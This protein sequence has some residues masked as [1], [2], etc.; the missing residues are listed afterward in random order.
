[1]DGRS[2]IATIKK[3]V[4]DAAVEDTI[5]VLVQPPGRHPSPDLM[6]QAIW[7]AS[8]TATDR[9]ILRGIVARAID[10]GIFGF[11]CV[12]DGVRAVE[13]GPNKGDFTLSYVKEGTTQLNSPTG[14]M[15]HDLY[16][17][18]EVG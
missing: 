13:D 15:L 16:N 3:V 17:D 1:M 5:D 12:V 4:R 8:L 7:Y 11:L 10:G 18:P 9:E 2:F 14:P 6:K